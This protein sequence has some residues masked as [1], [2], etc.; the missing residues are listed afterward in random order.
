MLGPDLCRALLFLHN[1]TGCDTTSGFYGIGKSTSFKLFLNNPRLLQLASI[2]LIKPDQISD[3]YL[4]CNDDFGMLRKQI[5]A[6]KITP[7]KS[8]VEPKHLLPTKHSL[9]YHSYRAYFQISKWLNIPGIT[10]EDWG[11]NTVNNSLAPITTD[12]NAAP[13]KLLAITRCKCKTD[14]S[15][16]RC[17]CKKNGLKCNHLCG[18]Y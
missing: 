11:W 16:L 4:S 14:C 15:T 3:D 5:L 12:H 8:F 9:K 10:A 2:F 18:T 13:D 17:S 1:F 7:S 6:K